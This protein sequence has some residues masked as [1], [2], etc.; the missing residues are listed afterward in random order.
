MTKV[1]EKKLDRVAASLAG[2][3][4]FTLIPDERLLAINCAMQ[5]LHEVAGE[6]VRGREAVLV[7]ATIGLTERDCV[8]PAQ[9]GEGLRGLSQIHCGFCADAAAPAQAQI[10]S[11]VRAAIDLRLEEKG[12]VVV[13]FAGDGIASFA[14]SAEALHMAASLHLPALFYFMHGLEN[15]EPTTR[16]VEI[17]LEKSAALQIPAM[18]VDGHDAVAVYRVATESLAHARRGHGPTAIFC[19]PF[20][21]DSSPEAGNPLARMQAYLRRKGL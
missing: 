1:A 8:A 2:H 6:R 17:M 19:E 20:P 12:S 14:E 9:W 3:D 18:A 4:G 5:R 11:A 7:S 13:L 16:Q 21:F 10:L 15:A